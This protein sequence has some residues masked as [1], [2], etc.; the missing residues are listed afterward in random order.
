MAR[1][2]IE[3][4]EDLISCSCHAAFAWMKFLLLL[5]RRWVGAVETGREHVA[6]GILMAV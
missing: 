6:G 3:E 2:R 1:N 4:L 5:P